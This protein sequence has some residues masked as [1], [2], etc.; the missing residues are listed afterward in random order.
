MV[1]NGT[2]YQI[3]TL[4]ILPSQIENSSDAEFDALVAQAVAIKN[5]LDAAAE[6]ENQKMM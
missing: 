5:A 6:I 4:Y 1:F 3:G 2:V